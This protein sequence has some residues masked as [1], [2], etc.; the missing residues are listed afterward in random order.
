M[1]VIDYSAAFDTIVP[2]KL[3]IKLEALGLNPSL[4]LGP[5]YSDGLL[6]DGEGR[7]QHLHLADP[8]HWGPTR[9]RA[10]PPPVL[11]VHQ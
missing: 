8:K 2:S 7:K 10:K 1:L 5:G 3:I 6:P 9:V 11:P 4:Q